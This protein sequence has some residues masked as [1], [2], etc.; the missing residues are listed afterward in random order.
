M[1]LFI[2]GLRTG[3][4]YV[5]TK[6]KMITSGWGWRVLRGKGNGSHF[7]DQGWERDKTLICVTCRECLP[8]KRHEHGFTRTFVHSTECK[9]YFKFLNVKYWGTW[10]A[11]S[12][13]CLTPAQAMILLLMGSIPASDCVLTAQSLEPALD[14]VSL[15]LCLSPTHALSPS[16]INKH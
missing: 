8:V 15:S 9:L 2:R 3:S 6:V 16:K 1:I 14:S 5:L 11:Q 10:V 12:V 4:Q 13:E 7:M